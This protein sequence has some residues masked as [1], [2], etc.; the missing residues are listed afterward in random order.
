MDY[1]Q[2][3]RNFWLYLT[4]INQLTWSDPHSTMRCPAQPLCHPQSV[5]FSPILFDFIAYKK[6]PGGGSQNAP[7][8]FSPSKAN[9]IVILVILS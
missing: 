9:R 3:V 6:F 2:K 5:F 1:A 8:T 4:Y 7:L